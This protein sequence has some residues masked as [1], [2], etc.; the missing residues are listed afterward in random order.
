VDINEIK[1]KYHD[2]VAEE[3]KG[4]QK[5]KKGKRPKKA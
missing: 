3:E 4:Q 2:I 5:T 1:K